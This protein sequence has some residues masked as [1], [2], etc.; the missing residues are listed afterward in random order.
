MKY[1]DEPRKDGDM[2]KF[3]LLFLKCFK[4]IKGMKC[5]KMW[6]ANINTP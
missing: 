1:V 4:K 3:K 6:H 2:L 5:A